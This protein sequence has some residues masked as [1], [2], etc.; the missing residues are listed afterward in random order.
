MTDKERLDFVEKHPRS[1]GLAPKW[2]GGSDDGYRFEWID[3]RE[4]IDRAMSDAMRPK[5]VVETFILDQPNASV[6]IPGGEPGYAPGSCYP[7][8]GG[9]K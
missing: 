9:K 7:N 3:I 6:S 8:T 1:I 5:T 4:M 2:A